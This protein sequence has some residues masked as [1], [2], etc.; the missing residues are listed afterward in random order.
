MY[1]RVLTLRIISLLMFVALV[2]R[3]YNLQF[4]TNAAASR[5]QISSNTSQTVYISPQR[6]EIFASDG[7]TLLAASTPTSIVGIQAQSLPQGRKN[8]FERQAVFMRLSMLLPFSDTL[9]ISPTTVLQNNPQFAASL[10]AINPILPVDTSFR[11]GQAITVSVPFG[12]SM[13]AFAFTK[14][15]SDVVTLNPGAEAKL[16]A[17]SYKEYLVAPVATD[18]PNEIAMAIRENSA[19]LPGVRVIDG[20]RREYPLSA[21]VP[22]LSHLLGYVGRINEDELKELNPPTE[23]DGPKVYLESDLIGKDGLEAYYESTL[24]GNLG[25]NTVQVDVFQRTVGAPTVLQPMQDGSNLILNIDADLQRTS[26]EIL[27]KW[28]AVADQRRIRLAS[29]GTATGRYLK[30]K[31]I[32]KGVIIVMDVNTGAVLA[33]VRMPAYDNN[34][35]LPRTDADKAELD[36]LLNDSENT[37]LLNQAISGVYPPGSSFKQF[38]AAAGL[39]TGIIRPDTELRDP[40]FLIVRNELYPDVTNI[41][42]NASNRVNGY[43]NVSDALMVSS[44][45]FFN[46]I[47]GGTEYVTNLGPNDPQV[48]GGIGID[49][50]YETVVNEYGFNQLT[51]IDLPGEVAGRIPN[52]EWKTK[53]ERKPWTVGDTYIA[54]IGQGDVAVTPIQLLRGTVATATKGKVFK[55]QVVKAITNLD[56][57]ETYTLPPVIEHH[58]QMDDAYWNIIREGMHRSVRDGNAYN[59]FANMN[60]RPAGNILADIDRYDLAGKTGTAE[61]F[62]PVVPEPPLRSHSWF[63]GFAPYDNPQI[64]VLALL[65][66]TGDL[67]DGS[68]TLTLPAVV[69][70]LRAYYGDPV[71]D[72][73]GNPM[74]KK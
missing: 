32:N 64:A 33:S 70:V 28:L 37:P 63:V 53:Q 29:T 18:V 54:A 24:R 8:Y 49:R 13:N 51:G 60:N 21:D 19:I 30:Y 68:G 44:N 71:P 2:L 12:Q 43:I 42:P 39:S 41:Y 23:Q 31:P 57:T 59:R 52:K 69:D 22:S 38:T 58:I 27:K 3:L 14:L 35:F 1:G 65:E 7:T 67:D 16:K 36:R 15:Y 46:S 5:Q 11:P 17:A 6:G 72:I 9:T 40:G 62:D 74:A 56:R 61:Y 73:N 47:A 26:E 66:G 45:V 4:G 55:P 48:K 50:L 20:F 25:T 34:V 10:Y